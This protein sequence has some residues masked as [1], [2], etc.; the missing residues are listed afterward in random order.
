MN[1]ANRRFTHL[2]T[3]QIISLRSFNRV[4]L[5]RNLIFVLAFSL[6][7]PSGLLGQAFQ[8]KALA[9]ADQTPGAA[10][11][12]G[13]Q[14]ALK[15]EL[16]LQSGV[17]APAALMAFSP[18][19][20]LLASM[21]MY[22]GAIDLWEVATGRELITI[23]LGAHSLQ[24]IARASAF[25][26]SPDGASLLTISSNQFKQCQTCNVWSQAAPVCALKERQNFCRVCN[27]GID[28]L[29]VPEVAHLATFWSPLRGY[30]R[31][32]NSLSAALSTELLW[33]R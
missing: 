1:K 33:R 23:N 10:T 31:F 20:Q 15:P 4:G 22:G 18:N 25:C 12:A 29:P 8:N 2:I 9:S 28:W 26:F 17:T 24:T 32:Q 21:S 3:P 30:R 27:A 19:G 13:G 16:V 11:P 5:T 7:A 6:L 14:R